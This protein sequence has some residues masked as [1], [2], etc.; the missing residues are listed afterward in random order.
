MSADLSS[1]PSNP[2]NY[3]LEDHVEFYIDIERKTEGVWAP[4]IA[5]DVQLQFIM[6]EPYYQV[7]LAREG[8]TYYYKFR[9]PERLGVFRFVVDYTRYG[10]TNLDEQ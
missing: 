2:E 10:L 9:V 3:Q 8:N 6:L 4:Y 7:P 1:C 5:D